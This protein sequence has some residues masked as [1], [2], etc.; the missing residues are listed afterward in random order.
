VTAVPP[1]VTLRP[2][3]EADYAA[4]LPRATEAYAVD[5]ARNNLVSAEEGLARSRRSFETELPDGIHT[6]DQRLL[7]AEDGEGRLVGYLWLAR[8]AETDTLF[9]Y[10]IEVVAERRGG[11]FGRSLM[12]HVEVEGRAMGLGRIELNVHADNEVA[13]SLYEAVGYREMRRQMVKLLD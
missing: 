6:P 12:E 8:K 4:Y 11:G 13:R 10:D 3:T 9:I 2:M 7:I 5:L 1:V